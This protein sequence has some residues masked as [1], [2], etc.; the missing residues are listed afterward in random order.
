MPVHST[1][2]FV[3]PPR[4][5]I[6]THIKKSGNLPSLPEVLVTL[7]DACDQEATPLTDIAT[8]IRKDPALSFRI[9]QLVNSSYY[10]LRSTFT[11]IEQAVVYLGMNSI[12]NIAITISI[13]QVFERK[14]VPAAKSFN[15]RNFWWESLRCATLAKRIA[16]KTSFS[17]PDEAY[18]AGLLN[19][20]GRLVLLAAYPNSYAKVLCVG[21]E[22]QQQLSA[23]QQLI[24]LPH[25]DVGAWLVDSW[26]LDSLIADA[27]RY[28]HAPLSL[29]QD[30]FPLVKII[31][32]A[33]LLATDQTDPAKTAV[34]GK[35]LLGLEE[36]DL[37]GIMEGAAEEVQEIAENL[38]ISIQAPTSDKPWQWHNTDSALT[39]DQDNQAEPNSPNHE[40]DD[41]GQSA[42][43]GRVKSIS[44][45]Y[46]FLENLIQAGDATAIMAVFEQ[47]MAILLNI[48]KVL[49]FLPD[50]TSTVLRG[51]TS[52]TNPLH[53]LSQGLSLPIQQS[54]SQIVVSYRHRSLLY[55]TSTDEQA[56][57]ADGQI[58]AAC[59][60][61]TLLILPMV[62]ENTTMGVVLLGLPEAL[63]QPS[64][65]DIELIQ[66]VVRQVGLSL[67]LDQLKT[68][69]AAE[70]EA[71]RMAAVS[72]S[73]RKFAHEINNPLAIITNY[74]TSMRLK[75][76]SDNIL[77]EEIC[78]I[79]EEIERISAMLKQMDLFGQTTSPSF[80][81]TDVNAVIEAVIQ[82]VKSPLFTSN[83]TIISFQPD[84][85]L[86][87]IPTAKDALKQ[88]IINLIK[89]AAEAMPNGGRVTVRTRA[90]AKAKG[91][92][93]DP[94]G[95]AFQ[96][97]GIEIAI[98]D[99]GPGL[100]EIVI[101]NLYKPFVTTKTNGHSGLGLSIVHKT[102]KDLGGSLLYSSRPK[103]G[104][105]FSIQLPLVQN[106]FNDN[107]P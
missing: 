45:L 2:G 100:P 28:H 49:F 66:L 102:V 59:R 36:N 44:L 52:P 105:S 37:D 98:E 7:L 50:R 51:N 12:K 39:P 13:H 16:R 17:D 18:L 33:S 77:R 48:N 1:N 94:P 5:A 35:V 61:P 76:A 3:I 79:E 101:N 23:E 78:I 89:N 81:S 107:R 95:N 15:I 92:K 11:G 9:L 90:I 60:C 4:E 58:F 91:A 24:G 25:T 93:G 88:V 22:C 67:Y 19:D 47:T 97:G 6:F 40:L 21:P 70:I 54:T 10:S 27:I 104:T 56:S 99:T 74:L 80:A 69:R 82:L 14:G 32:L 83:G 26:H 68:D 42:L 63:A 65:S 84:R 96:I 43:V 8:I 71:E 31:Y 46:G 53:H 73:A 34:A 29:V 30:S 20:I 87:P 86:P 75:L 85:S 57:V 62:A 103:E 106:S 38:G 41:R 72:L 64:K 55:L